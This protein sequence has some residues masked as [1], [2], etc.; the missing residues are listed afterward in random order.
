MH[1]VCVCV[2]VCVCVW[3]PLDM[4]F[5][6]RGCVRVRS[7]TAYFPYLCVDKVLAVVN[8]AYEY[9]LSKLCECLHQGLEEGGVAGPCGGVDLGVS[10]FSSRS[11]SLNL[12]SCGG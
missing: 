2:C 9:S 12:G 8:D 4:G 7:G 10:D 1:R 6:C 3:F 11:S 5:R